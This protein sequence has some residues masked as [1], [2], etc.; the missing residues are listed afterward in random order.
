M[1]NILGMVVIL[2]G[3]TGCAEYYARQ[4]EQQR[5]QAAAIDQQ[6]D[7]QCR[8]YGATPGSPAYIQCR[9]NISTSEQRPTC[10]GVH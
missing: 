7:A 9:M 1:W 10:K 5:M 2:I 8:N 3:L 4:A 6:E